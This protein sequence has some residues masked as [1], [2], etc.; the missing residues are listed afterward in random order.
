MSV[1][2]PAIP[3]RME[4]ARKPRVWKV[5]VLFL[6]VQVVGAL[7][8]IMARM[9]WGAG[10][11]FWLGA[12]GVPADQIAQVITDQMTALMASPWG[13]VAFVYGPFQL[14]VGLAA[15]LPALRSPEGL[16]ARLGMVRPALPAWALPLVA[17]GLFVPLAAGMA[18]ATRLAPLDALR[19]HY[20]GWR[21]AGLALFATV[22]PPFVEELFFRGFVQR[23]LLSRWSPWVAIPVTSALWALTHG[24]VPQACWVFAVGLWLGVLAWRTGS[25]W[26]GMVCHAVLNGVW[27]LWIFGTLF[28]LLPATLPLAVVVPAAV[29][30]AGCFL[31]SCWVLVCRPEGMSP[32]PAA[33]PM[34]TAA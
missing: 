16:R 1:V 21:W 14:V 27:N 10:Q 28:G 4:P 22:V 31:V 5:F 9:M 20:D 23:R 26:P 24:N 17:A 12:H 13:V 25:V 8:Q 33:V 32:A 3:T 18:L 15:V 7:A 11:G 34:G 19:A 30:I 6:G 2:A 29:L